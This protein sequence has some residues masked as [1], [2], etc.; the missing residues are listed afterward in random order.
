[1][2]QNT[3]NSVTLG[4]LVTL[5]LGV[6]SFL[7]RSYFKRIEDDT[8]E[9]KRTLRDES[10][11]GAKLEAAIEMLAREVKAHAEA[12]AQLRTEVNAMW[13][14]LEGSNKRLTDIR[15]K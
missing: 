12:T 14:F 3:I 1:M 11:A 8:K 2:D 7:A 6:V 13:R 9:M 10:R 15:G 4:G 5:A